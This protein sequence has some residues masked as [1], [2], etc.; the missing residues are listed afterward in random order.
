MFKEKLMD[1][2]KDSVSHYNTGISAEEAIV[3][4]AKD[5]NFNK[6][7][8]ERL[9]ETFNTART[10]NFFKHASD[11]TSNFDVADK[12]KVLGIIYGDEKTSSSIKKAC[13][14]TSSA[15]NSKMQKSASDSRPT[16]TA[17]DYSFYYSEEQDYT[18]P[19]LEKSASLNTPEEKFEG[20]S[21]ETLARTARN[22]SGMCKRAAE[23]AMDTAN[24]I[25][26]MMITKLYK[27]AE[28]LKSGYNAEDRYARFKA[29]CADNTVVLSNLEK[30]MPARFK[31]IK[32]AE[33]DI[34]DDEDLQEEEDLAKELKKMYGDMDEFKMMSVSWSKKSEAIMDGFLKA[35]NCKPIEK[36]AGG[37]ENLIVT[38]AGSK[39][40]SDLSSLESE[41]KN[42]YKNKAKLLALNEINTERNRTRS[43]ILSDLI[44]SD[45][46]ISEADPDEVVSAYKALVELSPKVS[47]NKE[48]VRSVLRQTLSSVAIS[49]YDAKTW[50]DLEVNLNKVDRHKSDVFNSVK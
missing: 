14:N 38:S 20:Y 13:V 41:V 5:H 10:I 30:V 24:Q 26:D 17:M 35:A 15:S 32:A 40:L 6:D 46:I 29:A 22:Q 21:I 37:I 49:P 9:V 4:S 36:K 16:K 12:S 45:P 39:A 7:Q 44:V 50:T 27:L 2:L 1:A 19:A 42:S 47:T 25:K 33:D 3:K 43:D 23:Q 11:K 8:T 28:S 18:K 48:V 31:N 34:V